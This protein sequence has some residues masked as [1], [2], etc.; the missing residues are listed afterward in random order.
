MKKIIILHITI[1]C[2]CL[3]P[4]L[5]GEDLIDSL[6]AELP[7]AL[8]DT[9]HVNL[10]HHLSNN[11]RYIN[12]EKG[13]EYAQKGLELAKKLSF[14]DGLINSYNNLGINYLSISDY[15]NALENF[16]NSIEINN[17]LGNKTNVAKLNMNIGIVYSYKSDYKKSLEYYNKALEIDYELK[18]SIG[19]SIDLAN[20][21]LV[22][23][24][25]SDNVK[26]LESFYKS[27]EINEKIGRKKGIAVNH[28]NIGLIYRSQGKSKEAINSFIKAVQISEELDDK[29][30]VAIDLSN[31]GNIYFDTKDYKNAL[32]YF[33]ESLEINKKLNNEK[34]IANNLSS[35]ASVLT[36]QKKYN[37]AIELNNEALE[38]KRKLGNQM[39]VALTLGNM[40]SLY[41]IMITDSSN[42]MTYDFDKE[43]ST[44]IE[45]YVQAIQIFDQ[46]GEK[47]EQSLFLKDLSDAYRLQ[48]DFEKSL[49][50]FTKHISIKDSLYTL[51]KAKE[52]ENLT[53]VREKF[54]KEKE[55]AIVEAE[56]VAN[57]NEKRIITYASI[58]IIL[59][60]GFFAFMIF[61]RLKKEKKLT[62]EL[63]Q[64]NEY[65]EEANI[66]L[67]TQQKQLEATHYE[68]IEKNEEILASIRYAETIQSAMLP[69]EIIEDKLLNSYFLI[70]KPKD[71]VSGD[72]YWFKEID[73]M[74]FI[75][76]ADCTGH[77]VP[78]SMLSMMGS[79]I[80]DEAVQTL[81]L[82]DT[83]KILNY[84]N[85]KMIEALGKKDNSSRDGMDICLIRLSNKLLQFSGA[86]RPLYLMQNGELQ[87]IKGDKN[88]IAGEKYLNDNYNFSKHELE[89]N[90]DTKLFLTSDG[91]V[92]QIG[93]NGKKFGTKKL[94]EILS[95]NIIIEETYQKLEQEFIS[96][97]G[98]EEQ[99]DDVTILG[100]LV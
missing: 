71:I 37:E 6:E 21:G 63:N 15:D 74:Q 46:I 14:D 17:K 81:N 48:G 50:A 11:L 99:R 64:K 42:V 33:K 57:K 56:N 20:I 72:F 60:I 78:G 31:I 84:L 5:Q 28:S 39:N 100:L 32:K 80:L 38:I 89:I 90:S 58:I 51:E 98:S 9:N 76:V 88:S 41:Y 75:A 19:I 69:K 24:W 45:Y 29:Y 52:I 49:D 8:G 7:S 65:I 93:S 22:Y 70:F 30:G 86:K 13:V 34:S 3:F 67:E 54:E 4:K 83:D 12:P 2:F 23:K 96:H 68:L 35:I 40:G 73:G 25:L 16:H 44:S 85:Q 92:D 66:E 61:K 27:L 77:G 10:L 26:A 1:F 47:S 18:D 95:E 87:S 53:S 43:L 79:S 62:N 36:F 55:L 59:V 97:I 82:T 91:F 94:K